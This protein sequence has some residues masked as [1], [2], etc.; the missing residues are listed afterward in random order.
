LQEKPPNAF[1][2]TVIKEPVKEMTVADL[3]VGSLGIAGSLLVLALVLGAVAGGWLVLWNR[4]RP[5]SRRHLPP[6]RPGFT[7]AGIPRS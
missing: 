7:D 1:V 3:I 6:V 5:A 2:V 4:W